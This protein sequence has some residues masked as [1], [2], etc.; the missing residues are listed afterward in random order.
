MKLETMEI[1][2]PRVRTLL[3]LAVTALAVTACGGGGS[4]SGPP[5]VPQNASPTVSPLAS[6]TIN[7][8]T[9]TPALA[10]TLADD[11]GTDALTLS[12]ISSNPAVVPTDGITLAGTGANRTLTAT[13]SEDA[14][15]TLNITVQ[16]K[17]A[18]GLIGVSSFALTVKAVEQS[19]QSY[20]N[21][22]Y[23]QD[24]ND[25]PVQVSGFTFVQDADADTTFDP[26]LQ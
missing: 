18:L 22:T 11:G 23:A 16:A 10:F 19:I 13:P 5:P 2:A 1:A 17:D 20:T 8:D 12:V 24:Q 15:G 21:S 9:P 7:Q 26:L 14:T 3:M 25:V 4:S 6:Q